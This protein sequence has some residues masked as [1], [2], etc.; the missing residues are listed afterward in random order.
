MGLFVKEIVAF[1]L[2]TAFFLEAESRRFV[3]VFAGCKTMR[4]ILAVERAAVRGVI[5][6]LAFFE[7]FFIAGRIG[8]I[9]G[10][11]GAIDIAKARALVFFYGLKDEVLPGVFN[12]FLFDRYTFE[13]R[14]DTCILNVICFGTGLRANGRVA[15][16]YAPCV[17]EL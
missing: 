5:V 14:R 13:S 11:C 9:F 6:G 10:T 3:C 17:L 1:D 12:T 15:C 2:V 16:L 7:L 4:D 8:R